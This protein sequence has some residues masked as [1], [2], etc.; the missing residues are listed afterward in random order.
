MIFMIHGMWVG[1]WCWGKYKTFFE[2][3]GFQCIIP[4]LPF[5]DGDSGRKTGSQLGTTSLLDYADYLEG[6]IKKLDSPPILMGH[7]M[8]GLL[9][10]IL[11]ARGLA[12]VAVL[13][14][15]GPPR[16]VYALE[17]SG[18]KSISEIIRSW[19]FWRKPIRLSFEKTV[20]SMNH[21]LPAEEQKNIYR[22]SVPESGRALAEILFWRKA[23]QVNE[24]LVTC[25][26]LVV[27][28]KEDR[29]TPPKVGRRIAKKYNANYREFENHAHYLIEEPGWEDVAEYIAN[30]LD[31][32]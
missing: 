5:H 22:K 23:S 29:I 1:G 7:S 21:L 16:G 12:K 20:Y 9:T 18:L 31:K 28:G 27:S 17:Y 30:W 6:E 15:P 19:G 25:P 13:L 26:I 10:Q 3:I 32:L 4:T 8:G 24:K 11:A 14:A 2:N